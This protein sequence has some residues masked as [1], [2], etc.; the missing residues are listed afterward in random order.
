M[1]TDSPKVVFTSMPFLNKRTEKDIIYD[2]IVRTC[3]RRIIMFDAKRTLEAG[4][5]NIVANYG[6]KMI[7][8]IYE[9]TNGKK[10]KPN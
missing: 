2:C 10:G 4:I 8:T 1:R 7:N 6:L 9:T 5:F 3:G